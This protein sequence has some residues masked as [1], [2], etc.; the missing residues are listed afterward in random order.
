[1]WRFIVLGVAL[2]SF[3]RYKSA[4]EAFTLRDKP[5]NFK[6]IHLWGVE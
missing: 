3:G 5:V 2:A 1:M 4:Q 6:N